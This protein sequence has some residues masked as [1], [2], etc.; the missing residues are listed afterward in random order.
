MPSTSAAFWSPLLDAASDLPISLRVQLCDLKPRFLP[1]GTVGRGFRAVARNGRVLLASDT[2]L[3]QLAGQVVTMRIQTWHKA[4]LPGDQPAPY[5]LLVCVRCADVEPLYVARLTPRCEEPFA[6][7]LDVG[8]EMVLE[9]RPVAS[10]KTATSKSTA[11]A[12]LRD[13]VR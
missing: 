4:I 9:V 7:A 1:K 8:G 5:G 13:G 11:K 12:D 2:P 3:A 6:L 10:I